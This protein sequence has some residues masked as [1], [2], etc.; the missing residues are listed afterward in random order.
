MLLQN[1]V[2]QPY[3][4]ALDLR[5]RHELRFLLDLGET[6]W[7]ARM[8]KRRIIRVQQDESKRG[9]R[10]Q[11]RYWL[12]YERVLSGRRNIEASAPPTEASATAMIIQKNKLTA[13]PA[14]VNKL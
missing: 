14:G 3:Q 12:D 5:C 10:L 6:S 4:G 7:R 13:S 2:R 8:H 11:L 9:P 1:L